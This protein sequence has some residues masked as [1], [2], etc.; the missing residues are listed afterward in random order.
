MI[1]DLPCGIEPAPHPSPLP[2]ERAPIFVV[3]KLE[4]SSVFQVDVIRAC[5]SVSPLSLWERARVRGFSLLTLI[6]NARRRVVPGASRFSQ[7]QQA[8]PDGDGG[9]AKPAAHPTTWQRPRPASRQSTLRWSWSGSSV[10]PL[11]PASGAHFFNS[12][13]FSDS[14]DNGVFQTIDQ[15]SIATNQ[16]ALCNRR[17][18]RLR[19][20]RS[21][22]RPYDRR[23]CR[24][25][26]TGV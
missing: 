26:M 11:R 15:R 6:L 5:H 22:A 25:T 13:C 23:R 3:F 10:P 20:Y 2:R 19:L 14:L 7:P 1:Q 9:A 4:F 24:S 17:V 8:E 16:F 12:L 18:C 21:R